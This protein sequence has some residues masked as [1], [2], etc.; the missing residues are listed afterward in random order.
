[1][2]IS[3]PCVQNCC[4]DSADVCLGCGRTVQEIIRWGIA[5]DEEKLKVLMA[6]KKRVTERV[7]S[8]R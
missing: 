5:D 3:S 7:K 2:L 8:D 6:S 1:M 4:L